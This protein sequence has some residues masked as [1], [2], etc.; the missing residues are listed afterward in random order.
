MKSKIICKVLELSDFNGSF[1]TKFNRFQVTDKVWFRENN[2]YKVKSDHFIDEWDDDKKALVIEDL[3]QCL[4]YGGK[5]LAAYDEDGLAGFA[6][7]N[8]LLFGSK[9]E[10]VELPYIHVSSERRGSG[11][12]KKLFNKCCE[13]AKK[14]GAVKL[15]IAAH[16]SV[17]SQGFY[18]SMGCH[19]AVEIN[20]IILK[21]E[22]LDLQLEKIL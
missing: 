19:Y 9:K 14:L 12:G 1:L 2:L 7:V 16:P 4:N 11:I 13:E 15:Y 8:G 3:C 17:E 10:Y 22:P 21:R 18:K 6:N 20:E 5:V